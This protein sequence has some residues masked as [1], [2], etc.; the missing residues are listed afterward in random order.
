MMRYIADEKY[1]SS[2]TGVMIIMIIVTLSMILFVTTIKYIADKKV[3][4]YWSNTGVSLHHECR[5]L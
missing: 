3:F 5:L 2:L 4:S 1:F